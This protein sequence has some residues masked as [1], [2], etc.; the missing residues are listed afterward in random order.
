MYTKIFKRKKGSP[1]KNFHQRCFETTNLTDFIAKNYCLCRSKH[2][3]DLRGGGGDVGERRS[4]T[5]F[6]Q[7]G[8]TSFLLS[9]EQNK[10]KGTLFSVKTNQAVGRHFL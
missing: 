4:L 6:A 8:G 2:S 3:D 10:N 1:C 9:P 5:I 7:D